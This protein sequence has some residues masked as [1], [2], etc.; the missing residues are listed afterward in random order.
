MNFTSC[1][2]VLTGCNTWGFANPQQG[3]FPLV[4]SYETPGLD[5]SYKVF[6]VLYCNKV[7]LPPVLHLVFST[8]GGL[9]GWAGPSSGMG[10]D[11]MR[12]VI[13]IHDVVSDTM[14]QF[15]PTYHDYVLYSNGGPAT[16]GPPKK[17]CQ[18]TFPSV[19]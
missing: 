15:A 2:N 18:I 17:V 11:N 10:L 4:V 9:H 19:H 14:H 12:H 13:S 3:R 16:K 5:A 8:V 6:T 1:R 7:G